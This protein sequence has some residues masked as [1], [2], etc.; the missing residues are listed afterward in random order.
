MEVRN[1][2]G[3]SKRF[4]IKF[5][6]DYQLGF[7]SF[8]AE[9]DTHVMIKDTI[10]YVCYKEKMTSPLISRIIT[11]HS[12]LFITALAKKLPISN[13]VFE[14]ILI[15]SVEKT[16]KYAGQNLLGQASLVTSLLL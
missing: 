11:I 3:T 14:F 6:T 10:A 15:Q 16:E 7:N 12:A 13:D 5:G 9:Q 2:F 8:S 4:I 1:C